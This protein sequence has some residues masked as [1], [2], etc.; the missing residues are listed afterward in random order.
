MTGVPD[1]SGPGPVATKRPL[2]KATLPS[3]VVVPALE[4]VQFEK[5]GELA[6]AICL[7]AWFDQHVSAVSVCQL[8]IPLHQR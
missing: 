4:S 8:D 3:G 2:P 6:I 5:S 7:T 1:W